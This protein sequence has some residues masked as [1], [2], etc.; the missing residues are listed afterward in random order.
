MSFKECPIKCANV[1]GFGNVS[2]QKPS[3][4]M[5]V[6]NSSAKVLGFGHVSLQTPSTFIDLLNPCANVSGFGHAS[7]HKSQVNSSIC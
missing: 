4:F 1:S 6:L 2:L 7:L 5:D 3:T